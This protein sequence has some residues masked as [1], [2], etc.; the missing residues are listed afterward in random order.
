M[1]ALYLQVIATKIAQGE[2]ISP[3][4]REAY[5]SW[6]REQLIKRGQAIKEKAKREEDEKQYAVKVMMSKYCPSIKRTCLGP[7]CAMFILH[8][9]ASKLYEDRSIRHYTAKCG[10]NK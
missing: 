3:E 8:E 9:R 7:E 10:Y 6:Q 5:H 2:E 1:D 4:D